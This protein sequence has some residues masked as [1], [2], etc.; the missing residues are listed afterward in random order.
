MRIVAKA[1]GEP[2]CRFDSSAIDD[3]TLDGCL[4]ARVVH[5]AARRD[6]AVAGLVEQAGGCE[7]SAHRHLQL[8]SNSRRARQAACGRAGDRS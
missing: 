4:A 6:E 8:S 1:E 5:P 2:D 3:D 7:A